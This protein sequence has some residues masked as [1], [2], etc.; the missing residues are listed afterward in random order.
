MHSDQLDVTKYWQISNFIL[1]KAFFLTAYLQ[2]QIKPDWLRL[3]FF[4]VQC[5]ALACA[6]APA[7]CQMSARRGVKERAYGSMSHSTQPSCNCCISHSE[8]LSGP[9]K[10]KRKRQK[11]P[12][13]TVYRLSPQAWAEP[14][15]SCASQKLPVAFLTLL[16]LHRNTQMCVHSAE[17]HRNLQVSPLK[18]GVIFPFLA[19][20][21]ACLNTQ[22]LGGSWP[23]AGLCRH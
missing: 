9:R 13:T 2:H 20:A 3:I 5:P 6:A 22:T 1:K 11:Q 4:A 7:D 16:L 14:W 18:C 8:A 23:Q 17:T 10:K 19:L 12:V 15:T 21:Q